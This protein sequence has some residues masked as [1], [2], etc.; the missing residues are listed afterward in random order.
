MRGISGAARAVGLGL[1]VAA[2]QVGPMG[3]VRAETAAVAGPQPRVAGNW[4]GHSGQGFAFVALLD[5]DGGAARLRIWQGLAE[6]IEGDDP[7]LV[8]TPV[9]ARSPGMAPQ[10]QGLSLAVGP[11]ATVLRIETRQVT[12]AGSRYEAVEVQFLDF[13]FTVVGYTQEFTPSG[14]APVQACR[15]DLRRNLRWLDGVEAEIADRPFEADN[16]AFW[17]P[18][19]AADRGYCPAAG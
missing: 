3:A 8:V 18:T 1:V 10:D 7:Q 4:A 17:T 15:V 13:Q 11:E 12:D 19:A 9:A 16:L 5:E 6:V 2:T 14:G